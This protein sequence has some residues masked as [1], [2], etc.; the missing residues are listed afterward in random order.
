MQ[1]ITV[2][3][4]KLLETLQTQRDEHRALFLQAQE[5]F[6]EKVIQV[7]DERLASARAGRK[8]ELYIALPEPRDYTEEFDRA[9]AMVQW[10]EGNQ[11]TLSESDFKRYVLNQ[12]EWAQAF[13][14]STQGYLAES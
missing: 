12:W 1:N 3:K 8:I 7:L 14:A 13:A 11:I 6:R 5:V 9:I 10:E 4:G 2:S